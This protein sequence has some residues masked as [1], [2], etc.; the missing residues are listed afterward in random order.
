MI[1]MISVRDL[2]VRYG[3]TTAVDGLTMELAPGRIYG[4]LGR[5]GSGKTSLLSVL[6]A[7]RRADGGSVEI[8]GVD[9]FENARIMRDT[10]FVRDTLDVPEGDRVGKVLD[11]HARLRPRWDAGLAERLT[12][13]FGLDRRKRVSA[14]SRGQRSGLGV[15]LGLASRASLTLL[16][17]VYLGMDAAARSTFYRELLDDYLAHPRTIILSTHLIQEVADL[18]EEVVIIDRGRLVVQEETDTFRARGVAVTGPAEAVETFVS[19][20]TV[21]GRQ[22]LGGVRQ[23]TLYGGLGDEEER[24]AEQAGLSLAPVGIQDLFVHL[25]S[26]EHTPEAVR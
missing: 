20:R 19:G 24:R 18:F 11:F 25:T 9:P 8:D 7:Y 16:D 12:E 5:N 6:A 2:T 1:P 17:E 4:L 26:G 23:A 14:L 3:A 15:V 22:S 10:V 13:A 21:L